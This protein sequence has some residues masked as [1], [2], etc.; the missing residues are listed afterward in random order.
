MGRGCVSA[1]EALCDEESENRREA[2][3]PFRRAVAVCIHLELA[4]LSLII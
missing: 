1:Q 4:N 2:E 3:M